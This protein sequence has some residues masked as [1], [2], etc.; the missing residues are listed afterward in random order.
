MNSFSTLMGLDGPTHLG[1][2]LPQPK[3]LLPRILIIVIVSQFV[4]GQVWILV[5]G[6]SI[7]DLSAI[8]ATS[9]G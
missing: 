8:V 5:L 2:E 3:Q 1:E 4:I 9:T 6:F 7:R